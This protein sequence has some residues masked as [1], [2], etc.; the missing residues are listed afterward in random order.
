MRYGIGVDN[1][2]LEAARDK[3]IPVCNVPDYCIDE[4]ADQT[5]AFILAATRGVVAELG[6]RTRR[7]VGAGRPARPD[8]ARY[9]TCRS[10]LW[11]LAASAAKSC[12]RLLAFKCRVLV[13]D[14]VV[15]AADI[16]RAG[17]AAR[18]STNLLAR[19]GR[20]YVALPVDR[21]DARLDQCMNRIARM[22]PGVILV[23]VA[24]GD[25]VDPA[26]LVDALCKAAMSRSRRSTCLRRSRFP[27]IIR[28]CVGE[29]HPFGAHCLGQRARPC[30]R[31][32]KR[33]PASS[34][35]PSAA[36]RCRTS[37]TA[38]QMHEPCDCTRQPS[39]DRHFRNSCGHHEMSGSRYLS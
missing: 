19:S 15:P 7:P 13:Y 3:H 11:A 10:A 20:H 37:S 30:E 24:R 9:A 25:L 8:A 18:R 34:P 35:T 12:S 2:D 22:K 28:F 16:E 39:I 36:S 32:A 1:V 31:C 29:C 6:R 4:V 38:W 5:L 27:P 21:R 33:R 26:A 17:C 14:P 23:N